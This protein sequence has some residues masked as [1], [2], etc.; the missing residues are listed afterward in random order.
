[1]AFIIG[2]YG[3]GSLASY[4]KLIGACYLAAMLF[5]LILA[6]VVRWLA[7]VNLWKFLVYIKDELFLALGTA[8]TEVVL[9][10]IMVKLE[11][12]GCARTTT[13]LVVPTS[14]SF[15]LDS[16]TRALCVCL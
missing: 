3:I 10:R 7:V 8:S 1:M 13:G 16:A 9:P 4:G 5:I 2:Q 11:N 15:T 6:L 14:Y 12:A